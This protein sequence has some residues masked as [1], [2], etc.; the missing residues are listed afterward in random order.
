METT[1][2][3]SNTQ[4]MLRDSLSRYLNEQY[5][6]E[7]RR[8]SL[9][10]AVRCPP[11]LWKGLAND[12]GILGASFPES[13][14]GLGGSAAENQLIMEVLG[15]ALA[16]EPYLSTVVIAGGLLR[17][18]G[19]SIAEHLL[20]LIIAGEAVFAFAHTES[21][22][23]PHLS[24][25]RTTLLPDGEGFRLD[26][27][28]AVVQNGPWAT[29][30]IVTAHSTTRPGGGTAGPSVL[31]IDPHA[32]GIV[33]RD[34]PTRDGGCAAEIRFEG[35]H[36]GRDALIGE[37]GEASALLDQVIDEATLAV[38]AEAIGLLRRMMADTL[39]YAR[40]RRQFGVPLASFQA[41]QHRMADMFMALEMA[42]ALVQAAT[43]QLD[44]ASATRR[45]AISSAKVAVCKA[46]RAV[47]QGAIQIHG[48]MGVTEELPIGHYFRRATLLEG[49]F[50]SLDFH[51]RRYEQS[52]SAAA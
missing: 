37:A 22:G 42:A 31:V 23:R 32:R 25:L 8:R 20:P 14:G 47:A 44:A 41:L 33:M 6:F 27:C 49:L 46:C 10:T 11:P 43:P 7:A 39:A 38:C 24:D 48:A 3:E 50:G 40:E 15:S 4:A 13:S 45:R 5:D 36:V 35:V 21:H 51:L 2:E 29:H 28:K 30:L 12:L 52:A 18:A 19:G 9:P 17:R 26:G 1:L 34:Y 16:S